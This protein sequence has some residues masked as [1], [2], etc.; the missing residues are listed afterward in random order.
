MTT[1]EALKA[2]RELIAD[3]QHWTIGAPARDAYGASVAGVS[4]RAVCWCTIGALVRVEGAWG[5]AQDFL[6][7]VAGGASLVTVNDRDGHAAVLNLF[8]R[9]IAISKLESEVRS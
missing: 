9:A 2:A 8:D 5:P 3:V 6:R 4:K 1:L 7:E